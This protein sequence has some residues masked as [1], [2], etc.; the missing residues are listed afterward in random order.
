MP[1]TQKAPGLNWRTR[2]DGSQAAYWVPRRDLV[3]KG[4]RPRSVRLHYAADDPAL[5]ARC[6]VLQADMLRWAAG[7][8]LA[9]PLRYD[10]TLASLVKMYETDPDSPYFELKQTTQL[11]Y[12]KTMKALVLHKGGKMISATTGADVKR[13]YKEFCDGTSMGWAYHIVNVFK[14]VLSYGAT[15]RYTECLTLRHELREARFHKPTRSHEQLTYAQVQA[16]CASA[17]ALGFPWMARCLKLQFDFGLRRRDVIGEY[18]RDDGAQAGIRIGWR[19]RVWR[20]GLTW[21]HIDEHGIVRKLVSKT[22]FTSAL[23]AVHAIEDYPD[24]VADLARTPPES[25]VG[26]LVINHKTGLP[27]TEEQCRRY[28]RRIANHAGIPAEVKQRHARQGANTEAYEAGATQEEAMAL[29]AHT[30]PQTNRGYLTETLNQSRRA[31]AKRVA[32]RKE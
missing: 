31:A 26:P 19:H 25:R 15:K 11:G 23:E 27:P 5:Y 8:R 24:V 21:Q 9:R 2:G 1:A 32:W 14:C 18:N 7:N 13:W 28:F 29:L 17:E 3:E 10:G 20:D 22:E 12:T 30:E 4:F 16:F 6:H